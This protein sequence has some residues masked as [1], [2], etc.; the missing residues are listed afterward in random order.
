L[1]P[2]QKTGEGAAGFEG[3]RQKKY[4]EKSVQNKKPEDLSS[5]ETATAPK[6]TAVAD[7]RPKNNR[8]I[9]ALLSSGL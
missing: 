3:N 2:P 1:K 6:K 5:G 8:R 4:P 9:V 7:S